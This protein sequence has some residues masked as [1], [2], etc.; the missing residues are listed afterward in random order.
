[1]DPSRHLVLGLLNAIK[2]FI[3]SGTWAGE[4]TKA[5]ITVVG[6]LNG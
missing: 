1:M 6:S 4:M 2:V 5:V 3:Y